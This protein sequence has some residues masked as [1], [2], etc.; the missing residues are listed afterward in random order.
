MS[1]P[2]VVPVRNRPTIAA[3]ADKQCELSRGKRQVAQC[4]KIR[5]YHDTA[6]SA[7]EILE[8]YREREHWHGMSQRSEKC[9]TNI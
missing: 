4:R 1:A 9:K 3:A 5:N 6:D 8:P 7:G 2:A